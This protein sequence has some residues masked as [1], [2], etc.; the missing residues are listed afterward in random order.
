MIERNIGNAERVVRF[1][2]GLLFGGWT[3][4]QPGINSVAEWLVIIFAVSLMLNGIF[5]RCYLW[6][7]LDI[8]TAKKGE[9]CAT[10]SSMS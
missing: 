2:F 4:M 8:N 3:L 9:A 5:S 10:S 7:V 1:F 6:F